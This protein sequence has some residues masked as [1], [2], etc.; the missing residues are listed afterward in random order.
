MAQT[1]GETA[2]KLSDCDR[3]MTTRQAL[4]DTLGDT[5]DMDSRTLRGFYVVTTHVDEIRSQMKRNSDRLIAAVIAGNLSI[6]VTA[7]IALIRLS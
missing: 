1:F 2:R 6:V 4:D 3:L 7:V 5:T